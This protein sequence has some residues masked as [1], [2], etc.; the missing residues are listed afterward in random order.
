MCV[1]DIIKKQIGE[2]RLEL[3][4]NVTS[5]PD[6]GKIALSGTYPSTRSRNRHTSTHTYLLSDSEAQWPRFCVCYIYDGYS[7]FP[8][9]SAL[10]SISCIVDGWDLAS[11]VAGWFPIN[12]SGVGNPVIPFALRTSCSSGKEDCD[13]WK[14]H[15][16]SS[17]PFHMVVSCVE[18]FLSSF[19]NMNGWNDC[20]IVTL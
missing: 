5:D 18:W 4:R 14:A 13:S 2:N 8:L 20:S 9:F 3:S 17:A 10:V 7:R 12:R 16:V 19:S 1:V 6:S 15:S 11:F